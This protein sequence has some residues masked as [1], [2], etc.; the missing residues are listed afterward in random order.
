MEERT[1]FDAEGADEKFHKYLDSHRGR[2]IFFICEKG[3]KSR[4]EA[5]LPA[6][7]R[8]SVRVIHDSNTKFL[9]LQADI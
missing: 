6:E 2:R 9:L 1:V 8:S 7:T 3:Q 4:I 5:A